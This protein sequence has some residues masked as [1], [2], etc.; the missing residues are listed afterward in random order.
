[1]SS[2]GNKEQV[3][4]AVEFIKKVTAVKAKIGLILGS[5]L[6]SF[7]DEIVDPIEIAYADIPHFP[8]STV[9]SHAGKLVFGEIEGKPVV[10]MKGRV[11]YYEGYSL[12]QVVFPI[13]VMAELGVEAF[14]ITNAAGGVNRNYS[15]GDF[16]LITDH[17]NYLGNN[18]LIGTNE[19][20]WGE[21]FP[22]MSEPY[23]REW[24]L[25]VEE[26][27]KKIN[28]NLRRGIYIA[29]TGPSFET[30]AEIRFFEQ[31]GADAVGMSTVPEVIV[32]NHMGAK[33]LGISCITNMAAGILPQKL[34]SQEVI[35]TARRVRP[36]FVR[37]L[38]AVIREYSIS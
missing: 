4:E 17:I 34:T 13:R 38:R 16:M 31:I 27:G 29:V 8:V 26:T 18:P 23:N 11:H 37:L 28:L 20:S 10:A 32:A 22:D 30:A 7:A 21:R 25:S 14:I 15:T 6:G 2:L 24:Y 36:D 1:M 33:V 3:L 35:D 19:A 9:G 5:G 12:Q